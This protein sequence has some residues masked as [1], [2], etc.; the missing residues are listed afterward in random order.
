MDEIL[1]IFRAL[2]DKTRLRIMWVLATAKVPLCVCE[3]MD[4]INETQYNVS[5]HL[6]ELKVA[7]LV[8]EEKN[9]RWV[10]YSMVKSKDTAHK[11]I[12]KSILALPR[13]DFTAD[14]KRL[15]ERLALRKNGKCVIGMNSQL[16][17]RLVNIKKKITK[18]SYRT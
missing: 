8:N 1:K 6:K 14:K 17:K 10:F 3:I 15:K 2:S 7:G 13:R 4:V 12:M 9:G 11:Y 18:V 5:R 16:W